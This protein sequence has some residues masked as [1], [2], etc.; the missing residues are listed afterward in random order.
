MSTTIMEGYTIQLSPSHEHLVSHL[1]RLLV[2][3]CDGG[4]GGDKVVDDVE[5][6][7][8]GVKFK[9]QLRPLEDD[10]NVLSPVLLISVP[11]WQDIYEPASRLLK[12]KY[13]EPLSLLDAQET[14]YNISLSI[15]QAISI[16]ATPEIGLINLSQLRIQTIGAPIAAALYRVASSKT[17][18]RHDNYTS[19]TRTR[20]GSCYCVSASDK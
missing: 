17:I 10:G 7:D 9:V 18:I 15:R 3:R 8:F 20:Y 1:Q 5:L 19:S 13:G 14:G 16:F 2:S 6:C 4:E 12:E 11:E